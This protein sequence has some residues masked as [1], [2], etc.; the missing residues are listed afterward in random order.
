MEEFK[1]LDIEKVSTRFMGEW[2]RYAR[3]Q[4][5]WTSAM[6]LK[7]QAELLGASDAMMKQFDVHIQ[8]IEEKLPSPSRDVTTTAE[9]IQPIGEK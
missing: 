5:Q 1:H 6:A 8:M 2:L 4:G 7:R 3:L 9:D